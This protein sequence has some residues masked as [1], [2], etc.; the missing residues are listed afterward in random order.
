MSDFTGCLHCGGTRFYDGP[1]G[2]WCVNITC[3]ECGARYNVLIHPALPQPIL[4][5]ELSGPAERASDAV[6]L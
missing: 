1:H 4:V 2:G 3:V 5:D 6:E